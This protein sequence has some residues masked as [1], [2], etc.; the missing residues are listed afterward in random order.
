MELLKKEYVANTVT[1]F[2][3]RFSES[4][5][6]LYADCLEFIIKTCSDKE[7]SLNTECDSKE[8]LSWFKDSLIGLLKLIEHKDFLPERYRNL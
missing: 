7:I 8:E 2:D 5:I 4:E 6:A 3:L 1:L